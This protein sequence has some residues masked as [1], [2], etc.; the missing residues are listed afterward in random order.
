[1]ADKIAVFVVPMREAMPVDGADPIGVYVGVKTGTLFGSSDEGE[2]W[3]TIA[4]T[5]PPI[6]SAEAAII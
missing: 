4:P 5:L 2:T 6:L 3:Q 1:M